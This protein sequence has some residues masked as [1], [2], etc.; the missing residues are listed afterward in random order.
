MR[1]NTTEA[2]LH[3]ALTITDALQH[4]PV[5]INGQLYKSVVVVTPP[6]PFVSE[7]HILRSVPLALSDSPPA[8]DGPE[9]PYDFS[10][11]DEEKPRHPAR[12]EPKDMSDDRGLVLES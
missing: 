2:N 3:D 1:D 9:N 12:Q 10:E 5:E 8:R 4:N 7:P 6:G 11:S